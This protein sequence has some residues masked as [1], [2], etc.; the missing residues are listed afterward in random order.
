M[1]TGNHW[2]WKP[3]QSINGG[4]MKKKI[5]LVLIMAMLINCIAWADDEGS[6]MGEILLISGAITAGIVLVCVVYFAVIPSLAE[7]DKPDNGLRLASL[8][9]S[10]T[11]SET[12]LGPVLG[13]LQHVDLG[14]TPEN[15]AYVGFRFQF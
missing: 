1:F 8:S 4:F 12:G 9:R 11:V 7:S 5:A 15:K 3:P 13:V 10:Q 6:E 14:V 2:L